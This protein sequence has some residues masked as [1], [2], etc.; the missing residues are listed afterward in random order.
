MLALSAACMSSTTSITGLSLAA[1]TNVFRNASARRRGISSGDHSTGF[2]TPGNAFKTSKL[3][4]VNSLNASGS[5]LP[6]ARCAANC[7]TS[8]PNTANGSSRSAS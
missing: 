2:G 4:R 5:A 3:M 6:I 1:A 7:F 8:S